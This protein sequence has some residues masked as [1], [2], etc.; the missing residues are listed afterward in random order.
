MFLVK[1]DAKVEYV[2]LVCEC[3]GDPSLEYYSNVVN[4]FDGEPEYMRKYPFRLGETEICDVVY[5][6][7]TN[8]ASTINTTSLEF[9]LQT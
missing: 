7:Y 8:Q 2:T 6:C 9:L 3:V 1:S 5:L 4:R